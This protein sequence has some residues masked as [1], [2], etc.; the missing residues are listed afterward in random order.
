MLSDGDKLVTG[1][2]PADK[3]VTGLSLR[4]RIWQGATLEPPRMLTTA[5][6]RL[7]RRTTRTR[8]RGLHA[9]AVRLEPGRARVPGGGAVLDRAR[10]AVQRDREHGHDADHVHD[11]AMAV[12]Y[13]L[14]SGLFTAT[15]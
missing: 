9:V 4:Q 12:W 6:Q 13:L 7:A 5:T 8:G 2:L 15:Q 11:L 3:L 1:H 10:G 14:G